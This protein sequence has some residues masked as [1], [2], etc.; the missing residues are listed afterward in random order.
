MKKQVLMILLVGCCLIWSC[1]R[2][3]KPLPTGE[4]PVI[5]LDIARVQSLAITAITNKH[6]QTTQADLQYAGLTVSV[7]TNDRIV[8]VVNYH[9]RDSDTTG[10]ITTNGYTFRKTTQKAYNVELDRMGYVQNV[11]GGDSVTIQSTSLKSFDFASQPGIAPTQTFTVPR[12]PPSAAH[13]TR[14]EALARSRQPGATE[15]WIANY[16]EFNKLAPQQLS[17]GMSVDDAIKILGM[18]T[19]KYQVQSNCVVFG[20]TGADIADWLD[21]HHQ[22][23]GADVAPYIEA[24]VKEGVIEELK[25]YQR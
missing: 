24:R 2:Q 4:P 10:N 20:K 17:R 13:E 6:P 9:L 7:S 8:V 22:P 19:A 14:S 5:T 23:E 11:S 18:P 21:W 1:K 25:A 3:P 12:S 15:K 16:F